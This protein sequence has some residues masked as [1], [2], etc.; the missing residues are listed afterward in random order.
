VRPHTQLDDRFRPLND[1]ELDALGDDDLIVYIR[2]ARDSGQ[3]A[4]ARLG[5]RVLVF[6]HMDNVERRVRIKVPGHAVD[7]VAGQ[8]FVNAFTA[9]FDGTSVGEFRSWLNTIVDR[10]IADYHR[11]KRPKEEPLA[12]ATQDQ[13]E[14]NDPTVEP[15][16]GAVEA[17]SAVDQAIAELNP[18]HQRVIDLYVFEDSEPSAAEVAERVTTETGRPMSENNVHQI[19]R[20][21][22]VRLKELLRGDGDTGET[23]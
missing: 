22:R 10:R 9:A 3:P 12:S 8:A 13:G 23:S 17:Q 20:R 16:T 15:E 7:L 4:A 5:L 19:A 11:R 21:F 2:L 14:R 1:L 6:G 18:V